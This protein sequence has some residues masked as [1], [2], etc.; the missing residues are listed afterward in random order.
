MSARRNETVRMINTDVLNRWIEE[1]GNDGMAELL[2][3]GLS[4]HTL[5]RMIQGSYPSVPRRRAR[6]ALCSVTGLGENE[7]FPIADESG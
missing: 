6:R 5:A 4:I 7:L 2:R 3:A 1:R